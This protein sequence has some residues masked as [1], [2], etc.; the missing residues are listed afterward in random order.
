MNIIRLCNLLGQII[1][2]NEMGNMIEFI[3]GI[4]L[5]SA[6]GRRRIKLMDRSEL[7][8]KLVVFPGGVKKDRLSDIRWDKDKEQ[9]FTF[10]RDVDGYVVCD[11][12][13]KPIRI[14]AIDVIDKPVRKRKQF[15]PSKEGCTAR[16]F[17]VGETEKAYQIEDGWNGHFGKQSKTWYKYIAKSVCYIDENGNIFAPVWAVK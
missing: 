2:E 1:L 9:W 8:E 14:Y 10:E 13:N 15:I 17:P 11:D 16:I 12:Y 4:I 6:E 3:A 5:A 7:G